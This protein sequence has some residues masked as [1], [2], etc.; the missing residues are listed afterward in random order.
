MAYEIL[1]SIVEAET[2]AKQIQKQAA[3]EAEA[4]QIEAQQKGK[5]LLEQVKKDGK[6]MLETAKQEAVQ[7]SLK[8]IEKIQS[9]TAQ[10]CS[11]LSG[12]AAQ[13]KEEAVRAVIGKVVGTYGGY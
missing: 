6:E 7:D 3:D 13:K 12:Q 4:L 2:H 1:K 11:E 5:A 10:A 8:E 9:E